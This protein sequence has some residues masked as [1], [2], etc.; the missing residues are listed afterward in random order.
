[1]TLLK[2]K[3][4]AKHATHFCCGV[5][6]AGA[7]SDCIDNMDFLQVVRVH[8]RLAALVI[9]LSRISV[10]EVVY[11]NNLNENNKRRM[12]WPEQKRLEFLKDLMCALEI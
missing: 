12:L 9:S 10:H 1:M 7:M 4:F 8:T 5:L 6:I 11:E 3:S 2:H